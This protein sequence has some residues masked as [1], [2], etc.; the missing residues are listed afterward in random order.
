MKTEKQDQHQIKIL[1][2]FDPSTSYTQT[3][4]QNSKKKKKRL[5]KLKPRSINTKLK[6]PQPS[7]VSFLLP[8]IEQSQFTKKNSLFLNQH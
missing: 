7:T 4:L 6:F 1:S 8:L 5:N 2:P 3:K